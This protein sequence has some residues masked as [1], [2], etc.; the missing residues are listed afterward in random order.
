LKVI[1]LP[2]P[3]RGMASPLDGMA[4]VRTA[5]AFASA[6]TGRS[7]AAA[8]AA[9]P[10]ADKGGRKPDVQ[11]ALERAGK[12]P[13]DITKVGVDSDKGGL[14]SELPSPTKLS[15]SD[16]AAL[17]DETRRRLRGDYV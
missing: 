14:T 3:T 7:T 16:L 11:Q 2:R 1:Q 17:P 5:P 8:P 15:D 13:P 12:L 4:R 6:T 9:A 10:A